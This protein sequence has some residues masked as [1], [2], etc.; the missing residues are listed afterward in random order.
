M[1]SGGSHLAI[2][3]GPAAAGGV[4]WVYLNPGYRGHSHSQI[5]IQIHRYTQ[6]PA[7]FLILHPLHRHCAGELCCDAAAGGNIQ[8]T[9]SNQVQD[10]VSKLKV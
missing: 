2:L 4:L 7:A 3:S 8:S 5:Q 10:K 9:S 6:G 1:R